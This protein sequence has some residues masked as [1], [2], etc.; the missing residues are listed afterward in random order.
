MG[1]LGFG[2]DE[3]VRLTASLVSIVAAARAMRRPP[4]ASGGAAPAESGVTLYDAMITAVVVSVLGLVISGNVVEAKTGP[5]VAGCISNLRAIQTAAEEYYTATSTY[6]A[7]SGTAVKAGGL[8]VSPTVSTVD[9]LGVTPV[10]PADPTQTGTYSWTY[11]A[12]SAASAAYYTITCPGIHPKEALTVLNGG[13]SET[14]G[15]IYLDSRKSV[16]TQ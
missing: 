2:A 5:Q 1:S 13:S 16:Y 6:P 14:T 15:H 9:Y 4:R 3:V 10:D 7:G 8:F 11:T 12:G